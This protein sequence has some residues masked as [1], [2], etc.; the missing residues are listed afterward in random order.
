[1]ENVELILKVLKEAGKPLAAGTI[2]ELSGLD[3]KIV[4]KEMK[5]M[6]DS[7]LIVSPV[8]CFWQPK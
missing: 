3:R 7:G 6:K 5:K 1:M 8:R 2:T 4:D